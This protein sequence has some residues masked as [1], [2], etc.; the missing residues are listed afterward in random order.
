MRQS[1]FD[2]EAAVLHAAKISAK[3]ILKPKP[4][5]TVSV[6]QE[7]AA[8]P[9][10]STRETLTKQTMQ[11]ASRHSPTNANYAHDKAK[12]KRQNHDHR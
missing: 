8:V 10:S 9:G 3:Q 2:K 6:Q 12:K 4:N 1:E 11:V 5:R 7:L